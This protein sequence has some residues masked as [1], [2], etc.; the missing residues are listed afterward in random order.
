MVTEAPLLLHLSCKHVLIILCF[1]TDYRG[2]SDLGIW[3]TE[4]ETGPR[5]TVHFLVQLPPPGPGQL[6]PLGKAT[7]TC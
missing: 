5:P 7:E 3:P 1:R 4:L 2:L 6:A